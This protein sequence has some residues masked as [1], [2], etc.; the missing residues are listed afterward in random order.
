MLVDLEAR[1]G[2]A[3]K[4]VAGSDSE[5]DSRQRRTRR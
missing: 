5:W 4:G 3:E 2:A 1:P